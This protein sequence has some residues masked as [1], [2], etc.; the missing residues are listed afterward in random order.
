[1]EEYA[2]SS[3][4]KL[5]SIRRHRSEEEEEEEEPFF[6][7]HPAFTSLFPT[8]STVRHSRVYLGRNEIS[9]VAFKKPSAAVSFSR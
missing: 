7:P 8:N 5:S 6:P 2:R 9:F 1:M 3:R 4:F